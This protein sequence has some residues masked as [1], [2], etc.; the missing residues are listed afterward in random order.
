MFH[1]FSVYITAHCLAS[2]PSKQ[3]RVMSYRSKQHSTHSIA[4]PRSLLRTTST[5][6]V[7][8]TELP[9]QSFHKSLLVNELILC[10]LLCLSATY[11]CT[12][13]L[14]ARRIRQMKLLFLILLYSQSNFSLV[15]ADKTVAFI[16]LA[17]SY[18]NNH[19]P[20][21]S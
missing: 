10:S 11:A 12:C 8:I 16:T 19:L 20:L 3:T 14:A 2:I 21:V 15:F 18:C 5:F 4:Y 6:N 13:H 7:L 9:Q 1:T 17:N